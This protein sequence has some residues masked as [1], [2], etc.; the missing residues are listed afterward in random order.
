MVQQKSLAIGV[1]RFDE[2]ETSKK[3]LVNIN[4]NP[5]ERSKGLSKGI[6]FS[7][8]TYVFHMKDYS[9]YLLSAQIKNS[10]LS[11]VHLFKSLGFTKTE[12]QNNITTFECKFNK[13]IKSHH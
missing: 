12:T 8:I 11:S 9:D 7:A 1:V 5:S 6:L 2:Y 3:F 4:L 13:I 10:N